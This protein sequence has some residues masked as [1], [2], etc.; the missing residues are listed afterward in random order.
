MKFV[1]VPVDDYY[2]MYDEAGKWL[3]TRTTIQ[4]CRYYL[5]CLTGTKI[6]IEVKNYYAA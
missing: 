3:G 1:L 2:E 5:A 6:E 4:E